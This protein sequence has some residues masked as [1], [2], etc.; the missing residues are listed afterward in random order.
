MS[1]KVFSVYSKILLGFGI[2]IAGLCYF[3]LSTY[4]NSSKSISDSRKIEMELRVMRSA[5]RL[6]DDMQDIET[7]YRG[8]AITGKQLY[9]APAETAFKRTSSDLW[10][11]L[12]STASDSTQKSISHSL[13]SDISNKIIFARTVIKLRDENNATEAF[14]LISSDKGNYYMQNIRFKIDSLEKIGRVILNASNLR[15]HKL[16]LTTKFIIWNCNHHLFDS[17]NNFRFS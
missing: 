9:L 3:L 16:P 15:K 2:A 10:E 1:K 12:Y 14:N 13:V 6:L 17:R 5:E 8:Y 4:I 7:A 11:L